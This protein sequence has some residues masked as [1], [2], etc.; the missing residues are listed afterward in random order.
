LVDQTLTV[1]LVL[2]LLAFGG[3]HLNG[4]RCG[5]GSRTVHRDDK[6]E[7]FID[8]LPFEHF[9]LDESRIVYRD[10]DILVINKPA[11]ID[12]QPTPSRFMGTVFSALMSY[13]ENPCRRD[14]KPSVGMMQR[15]DRDTSGLMVFSIHPRAHK[16]LSAQFAARSI[17]KTYVA[18]VAG[19][20]VQEEGEFRS[21]LAK[22]RGTN[23]MKSVEK[24]GD[25]AITRY[26]VVHRS[27]SAT[28][29]DIDLL[30]GRRHQI[31]VHFSEAGHP[32]LGDLRY[33]GASVLNAYPV[34]R[35]ML[36]ARRLTFIHPVN[37]SQMT[38]TL[39][40]PDDM[41]RIAQQMLL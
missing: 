9:F 23:R 3:I 24:W 37:T 12:C 32:L 31:R 14:L 33:D 8:G 25:E 40:L 7:I 5:D 18:L 20:V 21:L 2:N 27:D 38:F 1:D 15:L 6:I 4:R 29:V 19:Q 13:L 30:T 17:E 28:R 16:N 39:P 22:H 26:R 41:A 35:Q 36:H 11:G 34:A 10:D